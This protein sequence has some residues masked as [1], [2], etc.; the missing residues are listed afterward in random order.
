MSSTETI[1][2]DDYIDCTNNPTHSECFESVIVEDDCNSREIFTGTAC[3]I[4]YRPEN[5]NYGESSIILLVGEEM[6]SLTPS[7]VGDGPEV[8][9]INPRLPDGIVLDS[10]S[11]VIYG[12]PINELR[13]SRYTIIASNNAG[14]SATTLNIEI[15]P[16]API[17]IQYSSSSLHCIMDKSCFLSSPNIEGGSPDLWSIDP[18]LPH[19]M[20]LNMNGSIEGN[21]NQIGDSNHTI[22]I[23]NKGGSVNTEIRIITIHESPLGLNFTQYNFTWIKNQFVRI[24]PTISGGNVQSWSIYPLL[25]QGLRFISSDGSIEGKP[26]IVQEFHIYTISASNTG[27]TISTDIIIEIHDIV[28]SNLAYSSPVF[29]LTQDENIGIHAPSWGGGTPILWSIHPNLPYGLSFNTETGNLSGTAV[30]EQNWTTYTIWANNT[31]GSIYTQITI[32]ISNQPPTDISWP[33]SEY[34]LESNISVSIHPINSGPSIDTWEISPTLPGGLNILSNGTIEGTPNERTDWINYT[35]WANN[36]GGHTTS[37]LWI[38][39]HDLEADQSDLLSN[40]EETNWGGWPSP[41]IPIG[42]W[43]FPIGFAQGGYTSDIPVISASH[44]GRGKM[45]GYGHEGWVTGGGPEETAFSLRAVEW[46]CGKNAFVGLSYGSGFE[47]FQDELES[48]GHTV[49]LSV[50]TDELSQLDCLLDEFWNGHSDEDNQNI[51]DFLL[52]GGGVIMGGHAW[53]W[54]YSN[55]DLAHNYP[56]NKIAKVT[57]LFIS[58]A[59]GYDAVDLTQKPHELSRPYSAIQAI[60]GDRIEGNTLSEGDALIADST[61]S[62]CTGVISLDFDDFWKPLRETVNLSGWTVIQYGTLWQNVGYNLGE[63]Y[64]SDTLLRVEDT[65]TQNL[66]ANELPSH[67]SHIEFPGEVPV[68][69][70]R[71]SRL[72]IIDGNQSGLPSNFGYSGARS[73]L[74]MSTGLYAAPGEV[75]YVS[76]NPSIVDQG[77]WILIGAHSDSLWSKSQLH[78]F[79]NIVRYWYVDNS[80]MEVGN[81][82]GGPIYVVV[83]AGSTLG[84]FSVSISNAVEAP[85]YIHGETTL[86]EWIQNQRN[87]P[88]PW[89]EIGSDLFVM[90]VPSGEIRN[91]DNPDDLMDWWG[92]ALA[93]EHS[94]YGFTPWPRVERA[95]FDAQISAGWMHSGYPFMAHDLS[96]PDVIDLSYISENGDWGMFHELGHN[97]QWM[98][99]TLPGNTETSCNFASVYL[100]EDLVGS[101]GHG[102]TDPLQRDSRMRDYFDDGSNINNWSVWV[103]LDTHLIIKENWGWNVFT[104]ALSVYYDLPI[105]EVPVGDVEEFNTWVIHISNSTGYNLAPYHEAWGFPL[106]QETYDALDNLPIWIND[107]LRGEYYSYES[108]LRNIGTNNLT[109]TSVEINWETYDNGTNTTL[110]LYYGATDSGNQSSAWDNSADMGSPV[111][112]FESYELSG[113]TCCSTTYHARIKAS[114]EE[115]NIWFGPIS[116]TTEYSDD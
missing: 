34:I 73:S 98:P 63:D 89:A 32:S 14:Y 86:S 59:W 50:S 11:G 83:D 3:R 92:Q 21:T 52:S 10:E 106:E 56:G 108:I 95:V 67:P 20:S 104:D 113:L 116:W 30:N 94:L 36:T 33:Q 53:Y 57:G 115:G 107:P 37:Q 101:E 102:A 23:S 55:S 5:L 49:R 103:A 105:A 8:W 82:F 77:V 76:L 46:V 69:A 84:N 31:G 93:M 72:V 88:A 114:N 22:T 16:I 70:T 2:A 109:D 75:V 28:V 1:G 12:T 4:M 13:T 27:G 25:P 19:G 112:G 35:V 96:V 110:T 44:V 68:N 91:L 90:T 47:H 99:S 24:T 111:V 64:V 100:M 41:V 45:I 85:N 15:F 18:S 78:R 40:M 65:L 79:P 7:F 26:I 87:A 81:A 62:I 80:T 17:S 29:D 58:N 60:R 71:I 9:Q 39:I 48:E 38:V 6:Q 54:S 74:R 42:K 51:T 66:P 97:H 43:S 61:L